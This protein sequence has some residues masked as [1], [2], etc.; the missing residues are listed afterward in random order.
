ME[1]QEIPTQVPPKRKRIR[2]P[3]PRTGTPPGRVSLFRRKLRKPVTL[4]L[5]PT[6]HEMVNRNMQR[7]GLTRADLIAL[8]IDRHSDTVQIPLPLSSPLTESPVQESAPA[9]FSEGESHA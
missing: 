1:T 8:L 9:L 6:H 3:S 4:T 2:K 5:T 7:L